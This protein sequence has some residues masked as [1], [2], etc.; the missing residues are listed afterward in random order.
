MI[1]STFHIGRLLA[2][3][4]GCYLII[5]IIIAEA[6]EDYV[7]RDIGGYFAL[8]AL[9]LGLWVLSGVFSHM[10]R[11]RLI[12]GTLNSGT[13]SNRQRRQIEIPFEAGEAF[14]LIDA[15]IRE[16]PGAILVESARDSLQVRAKV[17]RVNPYAMHHDG[18]PPSASGPSFPSANGATRS[19]PPSRRT[20]IP[21]AA[22]P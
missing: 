1:S 9:F 2:A 11:V 19:W 5:A 20:A 12:A 18:Q 22:L 4:L 6:T 21:P 13:L 17:K 16:L 7:E 15:A 8:L 10:R 14:D 3:W